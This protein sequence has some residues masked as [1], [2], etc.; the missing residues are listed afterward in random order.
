LLPSVATRMR[1]YMVFP[2]KWIRK[3]TDGASLE[4]AADKALIH[5]N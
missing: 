1:L 4:V 3:W 2:L 5:V